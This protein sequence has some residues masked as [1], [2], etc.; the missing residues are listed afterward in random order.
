M[1]LGGSAALRGFV[2]WGGP[3]P[4]IQW[5]LYSGP[6]TVTFG[7][8]TQ[9]NTTVTCSAPG[10]YTL[11]LSAAD[12]VHAVAYDAV[13]VTVFQA[14]PLTLTRAGS[15]VTLSWSGGSP[16]YVVE[17]SGEFRRSRGAR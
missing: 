5:K 4:A 11:M 1:A 16:A 17:R 13:V 15:N 8:S 12:G 9:T 14:I 3:R 6:G 7:D 10:A 2:N